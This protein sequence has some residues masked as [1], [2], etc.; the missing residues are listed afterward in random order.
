MRYITAI[1]LSFFVLPIVAQE[2]QNVNYKY[3]Y[4]P[5]LP[6][7]FDWKIVREPTGWKVFYEL[8]VVD[9]SKQ[10]NT[11][12]ILW[13]TRNTIRDESGKVLQTPIHKQ[14]R[15]I[16]FPKDSVQ[17]FLVAKIINLQEKQAWY[18]YKYLDPNFPTNL[19][20]NNNGKPF[21]KPYSSKD[22]KILIAGDSG[23]AAIVFY[24]QQEF[25][26]AAPPF[27]EGLS[28]VSAGMNPDS[29]FILKSDSAMSIEKSGLYL[30]QKDT[31]TMNGIAFRVEDDYPKFRSI[32]K[33]IDPIQYICTKQEYEK[34]ISANGEKKAFD[35]VILGITGNKDRAKKFMRNYFY[36][37]ELANRY[38]TSYK[39]G[40]KTDRGMVYIILG[41][42]SSVF[43]FTDREV[44]EYKTPA[45][46]LSFTFI[47]SVTVFDP[48]N[49]V[50]IRDKKY[51][52]EWYEIVDLWR[53][54]RF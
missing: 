16:Y 26:P 44:W 51:Q 36:N 30:I 6:F 40:W 32:Q 45:Y 3:V 29:T 54:A 41:V 34:L 35:K 46:D 10:S 17:Q 22:V 7:T 28:R 18:F 25:P 48:E 14:D 52:L 5:T 2:L 20:V 47:R 33:L 8:E 50:L 37:V 19:V 23:S 12:A 24:Y 53:K 43:K 9:S 31:S 1:I 4:D 11:F 39:E 27:S 15:E 38:F 21:L 42:P 13:E 49:Y